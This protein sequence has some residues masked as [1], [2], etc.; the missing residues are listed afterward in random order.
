MVNIC[1]PNFK[2]LEEALVLQF[3][4]KGQEVVDENVG[5]ARAGYDYAKAHFK[6]FADARSRRRRSRS[7]CGPGTKLSRWAGPPPA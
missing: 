1:A 4:S 7:R 6:P 2:M 5:T 3:K